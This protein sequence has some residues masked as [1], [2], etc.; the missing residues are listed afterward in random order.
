MGPLSAMGFRDNFG[1]SSLMWARCVCVSRDSVP[2]HQATSS[3]PGKPIPS[4]T[5][6]L[7]LTFCLL[8]VGTSSAPGYATLTGFFPEVLA[9]PPTARISLESQPTGLLGGPCGNGPLDP[10]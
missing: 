10:S 2:I 3:S 6:R 7:K 4:P 5:S 1:A 8:L 9:F